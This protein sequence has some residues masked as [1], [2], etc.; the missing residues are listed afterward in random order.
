MRYITEDGETFDIK[1]EAE[2]HEE[3][4]KLQADLSAE[5]KTYL[6]D[7]GS[8][9]LEADTPGARR[10]RTRAHNDI[11]RWL[12]YDREIHPERYEVAPDPQ[13][14]EEHVVTAIAGPK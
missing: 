3:E 10:A 14:A 9:L 13:P 7:I 5:V 6:D 8:D 11:M 2:A 4:L 12:R 1:E